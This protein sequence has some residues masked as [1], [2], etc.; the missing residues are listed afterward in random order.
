[1]PY[2]LQKL[3]IFLFFDL[4]LYF[5]LTFWLFFYIID[6]EKEGVQYAEIPS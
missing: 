2:F 4:N 3:N 1:M 6:M 5:L